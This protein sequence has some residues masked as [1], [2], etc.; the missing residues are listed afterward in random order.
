MKRGSESVVLHS[1]QQLL[2]SL[3]PSDRIAQP[4]A[5][6]V[7]TRKQRS[8]GFPLATSTS[9]RQMRHSKAWFEMECLLA[10]SFMRSANSSI[11]IGPIRGQSI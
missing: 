11:A 1:P 3:R 9:H 4:L 6:A 2:N 7:A 5:A 8:I 10:I